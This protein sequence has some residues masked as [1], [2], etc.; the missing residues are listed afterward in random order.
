[1][2]PSHAC[3]PCTCRYMPTHAYTCIHD[4]HTHHIRACLGEPRPHIPHVP[5]TQTPM[6]PLTSSLH[7]TPSLSPGHT[8]SVWAHVCLHIT[9]GYGH[10]AHHRGH[11]QPTL[12][13]MQ[14]LHSF[15]TW[16]LPQAL[17]H[18]GAAGVL[19]CADHP[20]SFS[21]AATLPWAQPWLGK[22]TAHTGTGV[23][24]RPHCGVESHPC[25]GSHIDL[26]L[27]LGNPWHTCAR[28][29]SELKRQVTG[30]A[31]AVLAY[32]EP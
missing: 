4:V 24:Q 31:C 22:V 1:M 25:W 12:L 29:H 23:S 13:Y 16:L 9:L 2:H 5:H 27:G 32:S 30:E 20:D 28:L 26:V 15:P 19:W 17:S 10:M 11:P 6:C 21:H 14:H 18:R 8:G 7:L 3:T